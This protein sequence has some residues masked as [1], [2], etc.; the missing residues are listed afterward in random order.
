MSPV[1]FLFDLRHGESF[2]CENMSAKYVILER[3][4]GSAYGTGVR[5]DAEHGHPLCEE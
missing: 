1:F 3:Q 5:G 2:V 4:P